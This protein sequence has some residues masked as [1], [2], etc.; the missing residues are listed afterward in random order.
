MKLNFRILAAAALSIIAA[1]CS[2]EQNSVG[3]E[4]VDVTFSVATPELQTKAIADGNTVNFVSCNVFNADGEFIAEL[5]DDKVEM[6]GGK[7]TW[8]V[9]LVQGQT[10]NFTFWAYNDG[11]DA[12]TLAADRKSVTVDYSKMTA[13]DDKFDAFFAYKEKFTVNGSYQETV[14]LYRPFAQI[15]LGASD[16]EDAAKSGVNF[17][18]GKAASKVTVTNA[19]TTLDFTTGDVSGAQEAAIEIAEATI[20]SEKLTVKDTEYG[21][22][23]MA[24]VLVGKTDKVLTDAVFTVKSDEGKEFE[25]KAPNAPI[26]GNYRTNVIG[27]LY[28]ATGS[29]KIVVDPAFETPDKVYPS[30]MLEKLEFVCANG[31]ELVIT[32]NVEMDEP[33]ITEPGRKAIVHLNGFTLTNKGTSA[34]LTV[35]GDLTLYGPGKVEGGN[36]GDNTAITVDGGHLTIYGGEY[37]V[38]ADANGSGNSTI[39]TINGGTADIYN[40]TFTNEAQYNNRYWTLNKN[41]TTGGDITVYGGQ[42]VGF[43]PAKPDTDDSSSYLAKGYKTIE[44]NGSYYVVLSSVDKMITTSAELAE[45]VSGS[46][47]NLYLAEGT[48]TLPTSNFSNKKINGAGARVKVNLGTLD[49]LIDNV[50]FNGLW[51]TTANTEYTCFKNTSA[52]HTFE[53]CNFTGLYFAY[54]K[55]TTFQDCNFFS[56][57]YEKKIFWITV[58]KS[59]Y[60]VQMY[61]GNSNHYFYHCVSTSAESKALLIYNE[62]H[63]EINATV[64]NCIFIGKNPSKAGIEMHTEYGTYGSLTVVNTIV[65]G[66]NNDYHKGLWRDVNNQTGVMTKNFT[67]KVDGVTVQAAE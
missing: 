34:A 53:Y 67:V 2:K 38:G 21:Y 6:A 16:I 23:L 63:S 28:T 31:G 50:T 11:Q 32:E 54:E 39:Y 49:N 45:A 7:A 14:T 66:F 30:T 57:D 60:A 62:G 43:N 65:T 10:Y 44:N 48:Y 59:S 61:V 37:N 40:G 19:A 13:N 29:W 17:T 55:Q 15:N 1:A 20:P 3:G 36:G 9:A 46:N 24:Y 18:S 12:Y 35:N 64:E 41:N 25:I 26:Q 33:V 51:F 22:E 4:L 5:S 8:T 58:T 42:F 47:A 56:V 52:T 27:K